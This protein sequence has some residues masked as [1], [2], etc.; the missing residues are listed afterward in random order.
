ML[1]QLNILL[2]QTQHFV[3]I[4]STF[5]NSAIPDV[6]NNL[7]TQMLRERQVQKEVQF[8][9]EQVSLNFVQSRT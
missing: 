4:L 8:E 2:R 6:P 3:Y 1:T 5:L 9:K 7:K